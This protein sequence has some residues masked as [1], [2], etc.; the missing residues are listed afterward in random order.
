VGPAT[1]GTHRIALDSSLVNLCVQR[2]RSLINLPDDDHDSSRRCPGH[3]ASGLRR[4][5]TNPMA[6]AS[7]PIRTC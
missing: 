5:C 4:S 6:C 1:D 7:S 2:S 3:G